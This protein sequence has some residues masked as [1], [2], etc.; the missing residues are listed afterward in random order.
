MQLSSGTKDPVRLYQRLICEK[1]GKRRQEQPVWGNMV[2]GSLY[3]WLH[4]Y[5]GI[6]GR[7]QWQPMLF[8]QQDRSLTLSPPD[9]RDRVSLEA[10]QK[11]V[12][13]LH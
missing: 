3:P 10:M 5:H 8:I 2:A 4:M 1:D 6:H 13:H 11:A 12:H 9:S 7:R